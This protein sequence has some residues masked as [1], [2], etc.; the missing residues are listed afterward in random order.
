MELNIIKNTEPAP[1]LG[2]RFGQN[3]EPKGTYVRQNTNFVPDG[4]IEGKAVI[5][6]PLYIDI[7][8]D[9]Q[10]EYKRDLA[11]QYKAKGEKLTN[12]LMSKG[13]DAII[14]KYPD[15]KFGEIVL[16]SKSNFMMTENNTKTLIKKM[17][18]EA[19]NEEDYKVSHKA[20]NRNSGSIHKFNKYFKGVEVKD[21][22]DLKYPKDDSAETRKEIL[23]IKSIDIDMSFVKKCDDIKKMFKDY[24]RENDLDFP[25]ILVSD[26]IN[27]SAHLLMGVK[28]NYLRP[29][30]NKLAKELGIEFDFVD[31][32]T[33]KTPSFPSGHATQSHLLANILSDMFPK[34]KKSF[35]KMADDI[36]MSR[37]MAKVH[38]PSDIEAGNKMA[39]VLYKRYKKNNTSS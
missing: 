22:E 26:I 13:Y 15:G 10:I 39:D 17:L 27:G 16:F 23:K 32:S 9:T 11:K 37:M 30:P 20:S 36:S 21:F 19:L 8:D 6:N 2:S 3:V 35:E 5:N 34:H 24:F 18:N 38:Y 1:K 33:A 7:T 25:E 31:L 4:W 29:R 14:T 28:K 12:I